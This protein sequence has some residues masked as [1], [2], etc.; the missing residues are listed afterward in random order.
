M[1][2]I[3]FLMVLISGSVFASEKEGEDYCSS[4][5]AQRD[6]V[7]REQSEL[8]LQFMSREEEG[9]WSSVPEEGPFNCEEVPDSRTSFL[10]RY[11]A[12]SKE[13]ARL[14][15]EIERYCPRSYPE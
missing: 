6:R 2:N 15:K 11:D 14:D 10:K 8:N 5:R 13:K 9:S 1:K 4:F 7:V 12:L 3:I